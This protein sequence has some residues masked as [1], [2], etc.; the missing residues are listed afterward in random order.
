MLTPF[1]GRALRSLSVSPFF[2]ALGPASM[3]WVRRV[4]LRCGELLVEKGDPSDHVYGLVS[5][6]I[7]LFSPGRAGRQISLDI[8]APG[9]LLGV[10][11]MADGLPHHASAVA[12]AH[13]ELA[14]L[15][16]EH[17]EPLLD[18]N[19]RVRSALLAAASDAA[20]RLAQRLEDA[21][22]LDIE[23]RVERVLA[24]LASRLGERIERGTRIRVRQQDLADVLGVS[25]ESVSRVLTSTALSSKLE[26]RRGTILLIGS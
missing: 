5:G 18:T 12:L 21:A 19:P 13:C 7:K 24:D 26:V 4:P 9:E 14:A 3:R 15:S 25:R 20:R 8:L 22:F 1:E 6:R 11:G 16:R 23:A 17:L 2:Q 10:V